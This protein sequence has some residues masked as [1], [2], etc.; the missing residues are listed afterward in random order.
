MSKIIGKLSTPD[1]ERHLVDAGY[2]GSVI[3]IEGIAIVRAGEHLVRLDLY[4]G[5]ASGDEAEESVALV[6]RLAL[7]IDSFIRFADEIR[8][9]ADNIR[10]L[11][12]KPNEVAPTAFVKPDNSI[13]EIGEQIG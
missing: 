5:S 3:L 7:P 10:H 8:L 13:P 12:D 9:H 6:A 2:G 1:G 11:L 4:D